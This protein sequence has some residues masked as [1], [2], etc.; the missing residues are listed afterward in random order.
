MGIDRCKGEGNQDI[1][2]V[3][4]NY[5]TEEKVEIKEESLKCVKVLHSYSD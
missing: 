3:V 5:E 1:L 2:V 4:D